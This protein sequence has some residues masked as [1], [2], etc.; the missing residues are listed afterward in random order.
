MKKTMLLL[1]ILAA[2]LVASLSSAGDKTAQDAS[3]RLYNGVTLFDT[4][5]EPDCTVSGS[6]G[7]G[8]SKAAAPELYNGITVFNTRSGG[9]QGR[10]AGEPVA[11]EAVKKT[12]NGV[13]VFNQSAS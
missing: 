6:S 10:C 7:A 5:P 2:V 13:T 11:A 1:T 8:G 12:Y 3:E 4:G 9:I